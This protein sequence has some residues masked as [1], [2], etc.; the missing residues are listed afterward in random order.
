MPFDGTLNKTRRGRDAYAYY[1]SHY[2]VDSVIGHS[3]GGAVALPLK[4][5]YI[6]ETR[7]KP[8]WNHSFGSPNVSGNISNP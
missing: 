3:L 4:K 2:E 7:W 6:K 8:L 5:E 1:R